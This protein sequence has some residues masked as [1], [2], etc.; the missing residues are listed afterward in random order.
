MR[1]HFQE[2]VTSYEQLPRFH[3]PNTW[4]D[5]LTGGDIVMAGRILHMGGVL[6]I[7]RGDNFMFKTVS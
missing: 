2:F 7:R 4:G 1:H 6:Y 3:R 5:F